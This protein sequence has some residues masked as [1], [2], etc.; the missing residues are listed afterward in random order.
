[1][2]Y[3]ISIKTAI[4]IFPILAFLFTIPFILIQYHRY[5]SINKLRTLI[6]YSFIL[7]LLAVY[8]L[9]I[10]PLPHFSE[11]S[12]MK[13]V[14]PR[15]I[16]FSFVSDIIRESSFIISSPKTYIKALTEPCVYTVLFNVLMFVPFGM[17][18]RYYFKCNLWKTVLLSFLLS[19][20]LELT[21]LTGLYFIYPKPYRM[22]DVDDLIINTLG[23]ILGYVLMKIPSK[24]LP[25]RDKIDEESII[26]GKTVSGLRR[27]TMFFLDLFIFLGIL[28]TINNVFNNLWLNLIIFILYYIMY[29]Y[30]FNGYTIAGKFLNVKIEFENKRLLRIALRIIFIFFSYFGI[31]YVLIKFSIFMF[32]HFNISML[33]ILLFYLAIIGVVTFMHMFSLIRLLKHGRLYYDN[34]FKIEYVSTIEENNVKQ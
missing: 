8:F 2:G 14:N 16:P 32:N 21:Q 17:Y 20:F 12:N 22:F 24:F 18:L 23:G 13:A 3:L 34:L 15:L 10:L 30:F 7:Y 26:R 19:L 9:V 33:F 25:S 1:M 6:V 29:P 27:I 4:F 28:I 31:W 11:V 5:G